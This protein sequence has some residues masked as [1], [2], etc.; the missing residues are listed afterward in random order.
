MEENKLYSFMVNLLLSQVISLSPILEQD[1]SSYFRFLNGF[2]WT[3][4]TLIREVP[5]LNWQLY[6]NGKDK[7]NLLQ[8]SYELE[9]TKVFWV[10]L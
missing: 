2:S 3:G 7:Q 8:L 10:K 5:P 9:G 4:V 1:S 6:V